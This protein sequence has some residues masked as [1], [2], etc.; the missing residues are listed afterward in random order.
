M[1]EERPKPRPR[2]LDPNYDKYKRS[3]KHEVRLAN[4]LGG[5]RLPRSGGLPCSKWDKTT[6]GGDLANEGFLFE[7]KRTET[8][9][10][11]L[12]VDWLKKVTDGARAKMKD[13][14]MILTFE[15]G[16]KIPKDWVLI[17]LEVF[18][19]LVK[20]DEDEG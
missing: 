7:H 14:A 11:S 18:E 12:K 4:R 16:L 10:M 9:S 5:R 20:G 19:A 3:K 8:K 1:D 15:R 2:W 13:P 17:P 6:E